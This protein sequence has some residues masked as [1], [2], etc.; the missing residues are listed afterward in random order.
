MPVIAVMYPSAGGTTFDETYYLQTHMP[1]VHRH[2]DAMGL[3]G[4]T[5]MRGVPGPDGAAP[6]Y[7]MTALLTFASMDAFKTAAAAHGKEIFA[8]IPNFTSAQ[9]VVQFNETLG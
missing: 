9:P 3:S 7:V 6:A 8:D 2:W 4:V 5:L 1:L